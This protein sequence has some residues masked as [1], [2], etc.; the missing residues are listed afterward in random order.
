VD[1][2]GAICSPVLPPING[3]LL[4]ESDNRFFERLSGNPVTF[5][6]N[7]KG[8]VTGLSLHFHGQ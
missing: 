1:E 7:T 8:D 4:R 5:S 3:E 2:W 6:S